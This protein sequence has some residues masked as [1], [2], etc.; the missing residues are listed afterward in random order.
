MQNIH[1][2]LTLG[3]VL[4]G[5]MVLVSA[6]SAFLSPSIQAAL[7]VPTRPGT[8]QNVPVGT[9]PAMNGTKTVFMPSPTPMPTT[10]LAQDTFKRNDQPFWGM[11]SDGQTWGANANSSPSFI[12]A[13]QV[14]VI[15]NGPGIFEATLGP[16]ATNAEIIFSGSLS[17]FDNGASNTGA[18]LRRMDTNNW[19]KAYLD[20]TQLILLKRV[21]G[22]LTRLNATPFL[23][24]NGKE[25][26]LRFRVVGPMITAKVWLTGQPEPATWMVIANDTALSSGFGGLRVVIQRGVIARIHM[27]TEMA[28]QQ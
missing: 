20:G 6:I 1:R 14:G 13:G 22:A 27:F 15:A 5:L 11:A 16:R 10:L 19:Y 23:A 12:V 18:V 9:Q 3:C 26:T 4:I 7:T 21:A 17:L 24:Q 8:T 25:Y 2:L 28:V